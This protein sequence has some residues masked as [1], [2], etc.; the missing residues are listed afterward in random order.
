[1][2]QPRGRTRR[3]FLQDAG[4]HNPDSRIPTSNIDRLADQGARFAE[5]ERMFRGSWQ[6]ADPSTGLNV[7]FR[8]PVRGGPCL[9]GSLSQ[10]KNLKK[11]LFILSC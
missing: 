1:M 8:K 3:Q 2:K 9:R 7:D 5:A 6:D 11:K 10:P 4:G